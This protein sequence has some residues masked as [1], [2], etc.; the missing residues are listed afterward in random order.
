[1]DLVLWVAVGIGL[2]W[3]LTESWK[4]DRADFDRHTD[5][6]LT[7]AADVPPDPFAQS[8]PR[9]YGRFPDGWVTFTDPDGRECAARQ[10]IGLSIVPPNVITM[11]A[12]E[13][14]VDLVDETR[15]ATHL[16]VGTVRHGPLCRI[17]LTRVSGEL[18]TSIRVPVEFL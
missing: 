10:H 2:A 12:G 7:A 4:R 5:Q 18:G 9:V 16:T 6:A 17:P 15:T 1:M 11:L 3:W 8:T 13:R 14:E